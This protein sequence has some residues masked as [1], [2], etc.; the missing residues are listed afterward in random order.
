M[1][2][3]PELVKSIKMDQDVVDEALRS[4]KEAGVVY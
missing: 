4:L 1:K 3:Q 2:I